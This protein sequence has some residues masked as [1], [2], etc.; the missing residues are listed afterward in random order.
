[1]IVYVMDYG[2]STTDV[3]A[4]GPIATNLFSKT[5]TFKYKNLRV[6]NVKTHDNSKQY[7]HVIDY[8]SLI[9]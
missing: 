3:R 6:V 9:K 2:F 1:M 4:I 8:L 7:K 5:T